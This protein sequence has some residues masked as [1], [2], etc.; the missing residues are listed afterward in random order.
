MTASPKPKRDHTARWAIGAL[1]ALPIL[2]YIQISIRNH[3]EA[4]EPRAPMETGAE[5]DAREKLEAQQ[6]AT[7]ARDDAAVERARAGAVALKKSMRN[8]DS[9]T[10]ES[11]L[12]IEGTNAVC[13]QYRGQN[14]FGGMNAGQAVL[15]RDGKSFLTNEMKGFT[16][17]WNRDCAKQRGTEVSTA[18]RWFSL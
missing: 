5:R 7:K 10:L 13:F 18:I 1:I 12:V 6:R 17:L 2:I 11:A 14:G 9:F 4:N 3:I 8:P 16:G 15:G